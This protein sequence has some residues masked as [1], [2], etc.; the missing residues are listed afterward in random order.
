MPD[1]D[2]NGHP[3]TNAVLLFGTAH[4]PALIKPAVAGANDVELRLCCGAG[5]RTRYTSV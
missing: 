4:E 5:E 3:R 2:D 1:P